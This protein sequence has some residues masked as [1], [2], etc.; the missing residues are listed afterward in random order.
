MYFGEPFSCLVG[1]SLCKKLGLRCI[2]VLH[3]RTAC[4]VFF[5]I[6]SLKCQVV[7]REEIN[8]KFSA[9]QE[10]RQ[11]IVIEPLI[12]KLNKPIQIVHT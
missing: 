7:L 3:R 12:L 11:L 5:L 1:S 6:H 2:I 10:M 9:S 8:E 4:I